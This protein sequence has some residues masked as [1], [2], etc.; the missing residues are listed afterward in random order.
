MQHKKALYLQEMGITRWL[1]RN[2]QGFTYLQTKLPLVLS[3]C[4][5]L[6]IC[7]EQDRVAPLLMNILKAFNIKAEQVYYCT[8]SEFLQLKADLPAL[9][10]S[11]LGAIDENITGSHVLTSPPLSQLCLDANKKK[12]LWKQYCDA[13]A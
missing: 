10:W 3:T 6:I 9:I 7:A 4:Q 2:G 8:M 13:T 5:L 12:Q 11:T 1:L